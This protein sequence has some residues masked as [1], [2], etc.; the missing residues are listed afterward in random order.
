MVDSNDVKTTFA[1]ILSDAKMA[2]SDRIALGPEVGPQKA[3]VYGTLRAGCSN[4]CVVDNLVS[5]EKKGTIKGFTMFHFGSNVSF[6]FLEPCEN[7]ESVIIGEIYS[8]SDWPAALIKL[9]GL[10]GYPSFYDRQIVKVAC[11]DGSTE[12]AWVY[13]LA[14]ANETRGKMINSGDWVVETEGGAGEA[15]LFE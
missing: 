14:C 13:V 9:D 3:F 5:E 2:N 10:E 4:R 11:E 12:E 6:P 8:F 15:F 1:K 7:P